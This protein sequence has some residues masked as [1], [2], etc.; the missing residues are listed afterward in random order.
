MGW[1]EKIERS[2]RAQQISVAAHQLLRQALASGL[3]AAKQ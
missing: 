2:S 1:G 3:M